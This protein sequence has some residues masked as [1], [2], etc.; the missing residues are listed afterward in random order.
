MIPLSSFALI[1]FCIVTETISTLCFKCGVDEDERNPDDI[2]FIKMVFTKPLLWLGIVFWG[3]EL[4]AW[5]V[6][7]EHTPLSVAFPIMSFVYCSVPIAGKLFLGE[8]LAR[9]QWLAA[10]LITMGVALVGA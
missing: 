3:V 5:I 8:K 2:G 9:R 1:A 4:V 10:G 7:L 6:V